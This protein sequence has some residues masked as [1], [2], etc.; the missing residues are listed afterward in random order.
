VTATRLPDF[1]V[2]GAMKA[3]TTS[4]FYYLG[5]HPQVFTPEVKEIEFFS[6]DDKWRRGPAWY[7]EHF[8]GA[9]PGQL[10]GE[11]T[12][13]YT[14]FPFFPEAPQRMAALRPE[15]RLI[16]ILRDPVQR[17]VSEYVHQRAA[18][19]ESLAI[20]D[21]LLERSLYVLLS[22]YALQL[23]RYLPLFAPEQILVTT[24]E[25]LRARPSA[26]VAAV[27]RHIG[28]AGDIDIDDQ[29]EA[30]NAGDRLRFRRGLAAR[31]PGGWDAIVRRAPGP[32]AERLRT[33]GTRPVDR[34]DRVVRPEVAAQ[35]TEILRP[36]VRRLRALTGLAFDEWPD[37]AEVAQQAEG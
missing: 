21:A 4:L 13:S 3:G 17:M 5:R 9:A 29:T 12:T 6:H 37:Y 14:K 35:L 11:A 25:A 23:E 27:L 36:D 15:I 26:V 28:A 19:R 18:G 22:S 20:N 30:A 10:S 34:A 16:Y 2:I 8:A 7:A 31:Y 24:T 33:A 1:C 32:L